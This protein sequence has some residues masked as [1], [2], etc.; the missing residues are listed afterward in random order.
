MRDSVKEYY[1]KVLQHQGDLKTDACCGDPDLPAHLR[2]M[3][4]NIHE[5]VAARY[6][7]CGLI[8]PL[9]LEEA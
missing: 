7:G 6:Y 4:A 1:G 3:A 5:D 8:A 2:T 9:D